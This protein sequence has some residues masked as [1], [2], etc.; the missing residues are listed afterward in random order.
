M[1]KYLIFNYNAFSKVP[2]VTMKS[3]NPTFSA[4]K[5]GEKRR[6]D[7][8]FSEAGKNQSTPRILR[9]IRSPIAAVQTTPYASTHQTHF[10]V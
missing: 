3:Q 7:S 4:Q 5:R 9:K 8:E 10:G 1:H 2:K 6:E